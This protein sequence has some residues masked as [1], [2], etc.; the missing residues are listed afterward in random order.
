MNNH[1][2]VPTQQKDRCKSETPRKSQM[3]SKQ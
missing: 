1:N 2:G 3:E